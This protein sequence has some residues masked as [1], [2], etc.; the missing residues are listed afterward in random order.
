MRHLF[1]TGAG[2]GVAVGPAR[3]LPP[4][5][6]LEERRIAADR[7]VSELERFEAAVATTDAA[8]AEIARDPA[9]PPETTAELIEAH[10]AI[11]ASDEIAHEARRL[12]GERSLGAEWAVR[13]VLDH[14]RPV[15]E[16][17]KDERFRTRFEDVE[18]VAARLLR[19]L[20]HLPE[21]QLDERLAGG[22]GIGVELSPLDAVELHRIGIAGFVTERGGPTSHGAIVARALGVPFVFGVGGLSGLVSPGELV[23]VD[24]ARAEVVVQPDEATLAAFAARQAEEA[25]RWRVAQVTQLEP[26][27]TADGVA[28]SL[29]ANID[30]AREAAAAVAAGADEIGLVRTELLYLDRRSLPSEEEQLDDA[31]HILAAAGGRP[32][33]FRTLDLGGDKLSAGGRV[34][35]GQNPAL[36]LRG[37]RLSLRRR[38]LFRTQ[39]RALYRAA[40]FGPLRILFPLV[41][42]VT[43]VRDARH[44]CAEVCDALAAD[45]L[46]H[47]PH[48]LVGAMIE[49]PSAVLTADHIAAACDFLSVGTNDLI[50]YAFAA[51]RKNEEMAYLYQPM[52]PSVLRALRQ[53]FLAA[54]GA[55]RPVSVCGDMA[56]DP[57]HTWI[58]LGLGLRAFSMTARQLP[59]VKS[60][61]RRAVLTHAEEIAAAALRLTS[62]DEVEALALAR[63]GGRSPP[64]L[65][66]AKESYR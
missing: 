9:E 16:Q 6:E 64:E 61:V 39:L 56:G 47:D 62:H 42:T 27:I 60:M 7:I 3:L 37:I 18:S 26:S 24:A 30:S 14:L 55:D 15:F 43:E 59:F 33:T 31:V 20:L 23:C 54:A 11:L 41:S 49:T 51:D 2:S 17:M 57:A 58:L 22:I 29:G 65:G 32:V 50:Q 66:G 19:T 52:H 36:G 25:E 28:V 48:A 35:G 1:G 21:I 8:M 10:R 63:L 40:A 38:D 44:V 12:I 13:V 45:G 4:R 5:I 34:A 53:I 46:P